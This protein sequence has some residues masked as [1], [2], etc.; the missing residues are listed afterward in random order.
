MD[1][2]SFTFHIFSPFQG[3]SEGLSYT[4][5]ILWLILSV[6]E[7]FPDPRKSQTWGKGKLKNEFTIGSTWV[8]LS[9]QFIFCSSWTEVLIDPTTNSS[10]PEKNVGSENLSCILLENLIFPCLKVLT[11]SFPGR[12]LTFCK[13]QLQCF[14]AEFLVD[15][16]APPYPGQNLAPCSRLHQLLWNLLLPVRNHGKPSPDTC[17]SLPPRN[18]LFFCAAW[19]EIVSLVICGLIT[20]RKRQ[21]AHLAKALHLEDAPESHYL[22]YLPMDLQLK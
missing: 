21:S 18:W 15:C 3:V 13:L 4:L 17:A 11:V 16:N 10:P 2:Y 1:G 12:N 6:S 8:Y 20:G 5:K 14:F 19:I 7:T 22:Y 9:R